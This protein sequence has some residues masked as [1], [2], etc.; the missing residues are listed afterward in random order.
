MRDL[1]FD[2]VSYDRLNLSQFA[3]VQVF[4]AGLTKPTRRNTVTV[5]DPRAMFV[6]NDGQV[7]IQGSNKANTRTL[8]LRGRLIRFNT[9][10]GEVQEFG[11]DIVS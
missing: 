6:R 2:K 11:F 3:S 4:P 1:V 7:T 8:S 9:Y 10:D 5:Q